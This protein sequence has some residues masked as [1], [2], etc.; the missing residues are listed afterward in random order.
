MFNTVLACPRGRID[1]AGNDYNICASNHPVGHWPHR[2]RTPRVYS[3]MQAPLRAEQ[4]GVLGPPSLRSAAACRRL[5]GP[6][7]ANESPTKDRELS[8]TRQEGHCLCPIAHAL[9]KVASALYSAWRAKLPAGRFERTA[10]VCQQDKRAASQHAIASGT[11]VDDSEMLQA[12]SVS[13]CMRVWCQAA[14]YR[15]Y[16]CSLCKVT[17]D[18]LA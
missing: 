9:C 8:V 4:R 11:H 7:R 17:C 1:L 12:Q 3:S 10:S 6:V 14:C 18:G 2:S 5:Q 16:K 15:T 13:T